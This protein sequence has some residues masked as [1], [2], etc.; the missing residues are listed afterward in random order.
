MPVPYVSL[1]YLSCSTRAIKNKCKKTFFSTENV[2]HF[3]AQRERMGGGG[4]GLYAYREHK[5]TQSHERARNTHARTNAY[6]AYREHKHTQSHERARNTHARTNA[7]ARAHTHT[8]TD[9]NRR[10]MRKIYW[11]QSIGSKE[12]DKMT[13]CVF[14]YVTFNCYLHDVGDSGRC[15]C[16]ID[17]TSVERTLTPLLRGVQLRSSFLETPSARPAG[18]S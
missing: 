8:H 14:I 4:G 10:D 5:H 3:S 2:G 9:G 16:H 15:C 1:Y 18:D 11:R 12:Q 7:R 17:V 6:C 13:W